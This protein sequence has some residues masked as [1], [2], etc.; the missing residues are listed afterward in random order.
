MLTG[1][2][3]TGQLHLGHYVGTL[4][5]RIKF[6][7]NYES[8][9]LVADLHMLTTRN[10]PDD[11]QGTFENARH[12]VLD[13]LAAG[14]EPKAVTFYLQS[15]VHEIHE[16][17]TLLQNMVTV[18]RLERVPSLKEMARDAGAEMSYGLLGYPVLQAADIL[19]VRAN[20][21]PV[22]KDNLAHVEI[23][24]EIARRFN[25]TYSPVFPI[26][27]SVVGNVPILVGTDGKE[28]MS[29]SLDNA[30]F[31]TDSAEEVERKVMAMFT[32]PKRV[33]ADVPGTVEGNPIFIYH[34]AFNTNL[35]EVDDLKTRYR[36]GKV[37][38]VEVKQKLAVAINTMLDPIRERRSLYETPGLVEQIL[39]E[40]TKKVRVE[41][42]QTLFEMQQAMG[43]TGVWNHIEQKATLHSAFFGG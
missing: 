39:F 36:A 35:A 3:P 14:I 6:Q 27:E 32:D 29:K 22:G 28:K 15:A 17:Y 9:F 26:P 41:I 18:S 23:A 2:R 34:D 21:V 11:I 16:M 10:R 30:I 31:L 43:L 40:G 38:D 19:C 24:R 20:L 25:T 7:H 33:H 8:F 37:G 42:K 13:A 4:K 12:L 1:D 5:N